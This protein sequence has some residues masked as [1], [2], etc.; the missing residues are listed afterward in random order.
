M[1][2]ISLLCWYVK[3]PNKKIKQLKTD[4]S[5]A[6]NKDPLCTCEEIKEGEDR[7]KSRSNL[8]VAA[9][10]AARKGVLGPVIITEEEESHRLEYILNRGKDLIYVNEIRFLDF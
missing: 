7:K 5:R 6:E 10:A 4:S 1:Y 9:A 8:D 3:Y 2:G